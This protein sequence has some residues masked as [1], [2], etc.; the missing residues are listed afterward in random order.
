[1]K[2]K[3]PALALEALDEMLALVGKDDPRWK[4]TQLHVFEVLL[5]NKDAEGAR[6]LAGTLLASAANDEERV[7]Y[8]LRIARSFDAQ[9]E[10]DSC[11]T[12][13]EKALDIAPDSA[14][15]L[16]SLAPIEVKRRNWN[17]AEELFRRVLKTDPF[18]R[19]ATQG[20]KNIAIQKSL[21]A[22]PEGGRRELR[23]QLES[24]AVSAEKHHDEDEWDAARKSWLK[25]LEKAGE[26]DERSFV[27]R[28]YRGIAEAEVRLRRYRPA[29]RS[30]EQAAKLD[31]GKIET[32]RAIGDLSLRYLE[33]PKRAEEA[34]REYVALLPDGEPGDARVFLNLANLV[35]KQEPY[36]A[37][38]HFQ[39]AQEIGVDEILAGR[40][41]TV[42][43]RVGL[44][45]AEVGEWKRSFASLHRYLEALGDGDVEE[46]LEIEKLLNEKVLP[47]MLESSQ[48]P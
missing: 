9:G 44:L 4:Q 15:A 41:A 37:I 17:R 3:K 45:Y 29:M 21:E 40:A 36:L 27:A 12:E 26:L 48:R 32:L 7:A 38:A 6:R 23:K 20:L 35:A 16:L 22:D 28:S 14:A 10:L 11:V 13:L 34:Y 30:L 47:G 18:N 31:E 33:D 1:M 24:M 46:R 2:Q 8:I 25:V 42:D 19:G 39:R 5:A 43:K